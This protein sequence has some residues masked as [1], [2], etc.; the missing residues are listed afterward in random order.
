[1]SNN[2][3]SNSNNL[4]L[5]GPSSSSSSS[6]N[7]RL[8]DVGTR[9]YTILKEVGDG[10]FGTVWLA[11]W[12]SP[13]TLPPGTQP[14]GPS[15]R[16]EYKGKQLVA[17]KKMK[18]TFDGGWEECMKLKELKSLRTI[19]MHPFT[20][21]LYDAFLHP[22]TRELYFV[23]ECMEGNLY[24]LTK[25]RKGRPLAGGL[26]ACIFEQTLLG[27][28]HVHSCGFFH[29][30]MKPENLL[31]TTTGLI[32]YPHGSPYALPT[33]PPERDVAVILKIADFGL[34]RE[35]NSRPPYTEYVSTRW[36]RA[37]EVL[38]R[39]RDYSNPVDMWA[40]GAILVETVT[41]KPL[42]PGN[43]EMDQVHRICEI[44]GDPQHPYG[45]DDKGRLRGGG[46]WLG[47]VSLAKAVGFAFP[48]K[49]PIDFVQ[50]F[51]TSNIPIQLI[52]CLHELLRYE[53]RARLTTAQCLSH[54]Y[55]TDV[56]PRLIP[57]SHSGI[58]MF[59]SSLARGLPSPRPNSLYP[60]SPEHLGTHQQH[61]M[62]VDLPSISPQI[63]PVSHTQ[64][65]F[66]NA[67]PTHVLT[68][69]N[70]SHAM[71]SIMSDGE[72]SSDHHH[73]HHHHHPNGQ[74]YAQPRGYVPAPEL[75]RRGSQPYENN[76][77]T[78]HAY[79]YSAPMITQNPSFLSLSPSLPSPSDPSRVSGHPNNTSTQLKV[80]SRTLASVFSGSQSLKR[81]PSERACPDN[82]TTT[83]PSVSLS[84]DPKKAKKEAEKAAKEEAKLEAQAKREAARRSAQER[85]RAVLQ[86]QRLAQGSDILIHVNPEFGAPV[87]APRKAVDKGKGRA[88]LHPPMPQIVEDCSRTRNG[89]APIASPASTGAPSFHTQSDRSV[90]YGD[91]RQ[92]RP[93]YSTE[94]RRYSFN[95]SNT[96]DSD[97]GPRSQHLN[98]VR[99]PSHGSGYSRLSVASSPNLASLYRASTPASTASS[100]DHQLI[101][102][103][104]GLCADE[105]SDHPSNHLPNSNSN[106]N[107]TKTKNLHQW[108]KPPSN[109]KRGSDESS[110]LSQSRSRSPSDPRYSPYAVPPM[111]T[112]LPSIANFDFPSGPPPQPPLPSPGHNAQAHERHLSISSGS[113]SILSHNSFPIG[114]RTPYS[115]TSPSNYHQ[116]P[117]SQ[118]SSTSSPPGA[119]SPNLVYDLTGTTMNNSDIHYHSH[120]QQQ[121]QH[122]H[123][124]NNNEPISSV[125][126]SVHNGSTS[127]SL[128]SDSTHPPQSTTYPKGVVPT[129]DEDLTAVTTNTTTTTTTPPVSING[130]HSNRHSTCCPSSPNNIH[131]NHQLI[132]FSQHLNPPQHL[133]PQHLLHQ[134]HQHQPLHHQQQQQQQQQQQHQQQSL[135][136]HQHLHHQLHYQ[137]QLVDFSYLHNDN[138]QLDLDNDQHMNS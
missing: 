3:N 12:H 106:S 11:D 46:Q 129:S 135:Q 72:P 65:G 13:L 36:Y 35:T 83:A 56:A 104:A 30:D 80:R 108:P 74:A 88:T 127:P 19:P 119:H 18:K 50:L 84:L 45:L 39:A 44:M 49:V 2:N 54:S 126:V 78:S 66:P 7:P 115:T 102:N 41:L 76:Y 75:Q 98:L 89:Q 70:S 128:S 42:F 118:K 90:Y 94:E 23:F 31:I 109:D 137:H 114:G 95:S 8:P 113:P 51:D 123:H 14:P 125:I 117:L 15:S 37:P 112:S 61:Y 6:T 92:T 87:G 47:G 136:Q 130:K 69:S 91:E 124:I 121:Q 9:D 93:E 25:S 81:T 24:Q 55:F 85:S 28:H 68:P 48:D 22:T 27:L 97:P 10:S 64:A 100:L 96:M 62:P 77:P 4:S 110:A 133:N 103:M 138:S 63:V 60:A 53:P 59:N 111:R 58:S 105:Q 16:A 43:G 1:M 29:R 38:L 116:P 67:R 17:V 82:C 71:D 107:S 40:L 79:E 26:I 122:A 131:P 20:I 32:D 134:Q 101:A 120:Q 33:A 57:A 21:P 52:D 73:Q 86:K 99:S 5:A 132:S 34:A